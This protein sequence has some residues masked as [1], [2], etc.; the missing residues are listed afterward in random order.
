MMSFHKRMFNRIKKEWKNV[1]NIRFIVDMHHIWVNSHN[2]LQTSLRNKKR[3]TPLISLLNFQFQQPKVYWTIVRTSQGKY[4]I[5]SPLNAQVCLLRTKTLQQQAFVHKFQVL[6]KILTTYHNY[7]EQ[8]LS[9]FIFAE[10]AIV[11]KV[12]C[13]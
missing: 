13:Y 12:R 11:L 4:H 7:Y 10:F 1:G 3:Q 9:R 6:M 2:R 8:I 5:H